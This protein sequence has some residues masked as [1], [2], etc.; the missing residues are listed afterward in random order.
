MVLSELVTGRL[1]IALYRSKEYVV[2]LSQVEGVLGERK[3][4]F[5]KEQPGCNVGF[6]YL[7]L[8]AHVFRACGMS[9]V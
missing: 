7:V 2:C 6:R 8:S 3:G 1:R 9:I 4:G 5:R